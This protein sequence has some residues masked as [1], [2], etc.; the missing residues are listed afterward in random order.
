[1]YQGGFAFLLILMTVVV[2]NDIVRAVV[3]KP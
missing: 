2:Y 1:V 3:S